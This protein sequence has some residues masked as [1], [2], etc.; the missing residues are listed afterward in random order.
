MLSLVSDDQ[1]YHLTHILLA[2]SVKLGLLANFFYRKESIRLVFFPQK[3]IETLQMIPT[4]R[5]YRK[6]YKTG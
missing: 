5:G 3:T 4:Y 6:L 1:G 2:W